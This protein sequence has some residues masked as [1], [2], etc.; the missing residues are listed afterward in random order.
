MAYKAGECGQADGM[1]IIAGCPLMVDAV[2]IAAVA[3]GMRQ[4]ELGRDPS[5]G[6]MALVASHAREQP[7]VVGWVGVTGNT[8]R[9]EN[10]K[11]R[12]GVAFCTSQPGMCT[13]Q[14]EFRQRMVERGGQPA[15]GGVTGAAS[16][17]KLAF[18]CVILCM[19]AGAVLGGRF[20]VRDASCPRMAASA[21]QWDVFPGQFKG[22]GGMAE[23]VTV[24][25]DPIVA[26]QAVITI[27]LQ[28]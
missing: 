27:S 1:T 20:Q 26:S 12:I 4:V 6:G 13:G 2:L 19:A 24:A 11:N 7:G 23:S 18:V 3:G 25:V 8:R 14:W 21:V 9:R 28:V 15:L 22:D 10:G 16:I 17:A 5:C